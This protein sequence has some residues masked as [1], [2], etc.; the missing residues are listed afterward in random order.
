MTM[1]RAA[2]TESPEFDDMELD[3]LD[4]FL[5]PFM[6]PYVW[7]R[8]LVTTPFQY[9]RLLRTNRKI[10]WRPLTIEQI[11]GLSQPVHEF[12]HNMEAA[13]GRI[14]FHEP[15]RHADASR[16]HDREG[17]TVITIAPSASGEEFCMAV[18]THAPRRFSMTGLSFHTRMTDGLVIV[19][20]N[21]RRV[22]SAR[23]GKHDVVAFQR[24][25]DAARLYE[26]HQGRK[27]VAV[28]EGSAPVKVGW[29]PP[30]MHPLDAYQRMFD[31]AIDGGVRRGYVEAPAT[32][33]VRVTFKG[34]VLAAW[35]S[36]WPLNQILDW[37]EGRRAAQVL[38]DLQA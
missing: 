5:I 31:E 9:R 36:A 17:A 23:Q 30:T 28:R 6:M 34:A 2:P 15:V 8:G 37:R 24:V 19:T 38:R 7:L 20:G 35:S 1:T 16:P 10:G 13:T 25:T 27:A 4:R 11:S 18:I 22:I 14:G 29:H 26:I 12:L 32:E 21:E 3:G 33:A